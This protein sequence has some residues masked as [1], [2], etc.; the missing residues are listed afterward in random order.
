MIGR[1]FLLL[2][3]IVL[4]HALYSA[5]HYKS[6][7]SQAIDLPI[8]II[9]E[10]SIAFILLLIG[11]TLPLNLKAVRLSTDVITKTVDQIYG[12]PDFLTF[13]NRTKQI[14]NRKLRAAKK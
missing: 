8:D 1:L 12:R 6:L 7:F 14:Y 5:H 13:N 4:L 11:Q 2:G 9:I 10:V 3:S